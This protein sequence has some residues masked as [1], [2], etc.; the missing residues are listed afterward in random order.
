MSAM[1]FKACAYKLSR[2][3][4]HIL[5]LSLMQEKVLVQWPTTLSSTSTEENHLIGSQRLQTC[6][7]V[8]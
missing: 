4:H 1:V 6:A 3:L 2:V 7:S 8:T 5:K